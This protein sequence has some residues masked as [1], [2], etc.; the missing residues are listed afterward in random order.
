MS[1]ILEAILGASNGG[2]VEQLST[3]F[4]L[5]GNQTTS[6]IKSLLPALSRGVQRNMQGGGE[7]GLLGA[8]QG[9][10]HSRFLEQ[11]NLLSQAATTQ[12][13][14]GILGHILGSKD[15][16]RAV[17]ARASEKSGVDTGILKKM[18]PL[19]A[20]MFMGGMGKK[21][22]SGGL[23]G[24]AA[25]MLGGQ[26]QESSGLLGAAAGLLG[27]GQKEEKKSS[28]GL[29]GLLGGFLGGGDDDDDDGFGLDDVLGIA[30]KIF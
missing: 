5:S 20:T 11:P 4:G 23:L 25:G 22:D 18:L 29:A 15:V 27:G 17:A 21:A 9:G 8:L 14:N 1:G 10:K 19:V 16:S 30:K 2:A 6:A 13:G 28:G 24:A 3:Q 26:K 12:E 7:S